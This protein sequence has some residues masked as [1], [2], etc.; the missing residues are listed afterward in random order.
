MGFVQSSK[1]DFIFADDISAQLTKHLVFLFLKLLNI[2]GATDLDT[3]ILYFF[4]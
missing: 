4:H 3:K 1:C 2:V